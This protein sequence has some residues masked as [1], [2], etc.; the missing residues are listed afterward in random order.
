MALFTAFIARFVFVG[1][2]IKLVNQ[3]PQNFQPFT[4]FFV[5]DFAAALGDGKT[6]LPSLYT[7]RPSSLTTLKV[8][9]LPLNTFLNSRPA[10]RFGLIFFLGMV[11]F[12]VIGT[13]LL[14]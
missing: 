6:D 5:I 11:F 2:T 1:G 3:L 14:F 8:Y 10:F 4:S 7:I 9:G 12:F 13:Q